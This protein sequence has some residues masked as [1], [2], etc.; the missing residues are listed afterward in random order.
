MGRIYLYKKN[1]LGVCAVLLLISTP[2]F[3]SAQSDT[4]VSVTISYGPV[5]YAVCDQQECISASNAD[6]RLYSTNTG[7]SLTDAPRYSTS[8]NQSEGD[9]AW[10]KTGSPA[11]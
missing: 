7:S 2:Y 6:G 5:I 3:V 1:M 4:A 8:P 10:S 9:S 11:W